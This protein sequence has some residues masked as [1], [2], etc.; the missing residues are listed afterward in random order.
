MCAWLRLLVCPDVSTH[1][2]C[3]EIT[4]GFA[5][6]VTDERGSGHAYT[7]LRVSLWE[8]SARPLTMAPRDKFGPFQSM[9][10]LIFP[11]HVFHCK[12]IV[13]GM[14]GVPLIGIHSEASTCKCFK[15]RRVSADTAIH[16]SQACDPSTA[17]GR[18]HF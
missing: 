14:C 7:S 12:P 15:A 11:L 10:A 13:S 5:R 8:G 1:S 3:I 9:R 17:Q 6:Q 18:I 4:P 16:H 2:L